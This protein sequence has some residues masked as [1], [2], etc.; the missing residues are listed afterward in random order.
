[1]FRPKRGR[2]VTLRVLV[3]SK[4][5]TTTTLVISRAKG[6]EETHIAWSHYRRFEAADQ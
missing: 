3:V 4:T 5:Y 2:P 6:A 1:M